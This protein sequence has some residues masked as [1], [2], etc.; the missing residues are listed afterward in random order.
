MTSTL[1]AGFTWR[2]PAL[3]GDDGGAD[4]DLALAVVHAH[5]SAVL[6]VPSD[7]TREHL[8]G[9]MRLPGTDLGASVLVLDGDG[10]PVGYVIV[11][12]DETLNTIFVNAYVDPSSTADYPDLLDDLIAHALRYGRAIAHERESTWELACGGYAEDVAYGDAL[13]RAGFGIVRHFFRMRIDLIESPPREPEPWPAGVTIETAVTEAQQRDIWEVAEASFAD[14]WR[15]V[16]R[17]FNEWRERMTAASELPDPDL[18][19]LVRV[20]GVPAAFLVGD[21]SR[22]HL[23][24]GYVSELGVVREFRGQGLARGLL[25]RHFHA[26]ATAGYNGVQLG[27]DASNPTGALQLYESVGMT[28]HQ[29]LIARHFT[30]GPTGEQVANR[31]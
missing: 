30:W 14:H 15:A 25:L 11:E 7:T 13:E 31:P 6:P 23:G 16:W 17:P 3:V 1:P 4:V 8:L 9:E 5:E 10:R 28:M 18:W 21:R 27:V 2:A 19:W 20:D 22:A 29:H 26:T 12:Q 24:D